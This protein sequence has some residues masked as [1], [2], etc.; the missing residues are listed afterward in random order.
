MKALARRLLGISPPLLAWAR[1]WTAVARGR[2]IGADRFLRFA[3]PGHYYSPLPAESAYLAATGS[4]PTPAPQE[5]LPGIDLRL[6]DQLTLF[7]QLAPQLAKFSPSAAPVP[8]RR[9]YYGN[10]FFGRGEAGIAAALLQEDRPRRV[11]EVGSGF[12]SAL[13]LDTAGAGSGEAVEFTFLDPDPVR[14]DALLRPAD[15]ARVRV[16]KGLA[17]DQSP[18]FYGTLEPGDWLFV[19]SSHVGK[20]GSDVLYLLFEVFPRLKPGVTVH[21][22]DVFWPFEYP[23]AWYEEGRAWNEA[24]FLRTHLIENPRWRI[25]FWNDCFWKAHPDVVR[26]TFPGVEGLGASLWLRRD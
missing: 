26:S 6:A 22:H 20:C 16:I 4:T 9:Y 10:D 1:N 3:P 8:D 18:A 15:R 25:R 11:I 14:L 7:R 2:R 5:G 19:D 21:L 24:Y 13:L 23:R 17:Q 12:S